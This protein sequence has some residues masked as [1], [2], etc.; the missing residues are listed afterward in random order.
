MTTKKH[1]AAHE[2]ALAAFAED[3][4][5]WAA[6]KR[7]LRG[8]EA[9]AFGRNMLAAAGVDIDALERRVGRPRVGRKESA[10]KGVRSPRV[11]V[12][13]SMHT[14]EQLT[15]LGIRRGVSRS[16]LVRQALE[17]YLSHAG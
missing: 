8:N 16:E 4:S 15:Q 11:N 10:S 3:F 7:T 13:I 5:K 14:D 2:D 9:A 1:A 12:A 17:E 6:P